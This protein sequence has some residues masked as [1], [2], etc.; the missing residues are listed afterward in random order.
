M[1]TARSDPMKPVMHAPRP[2]G[3]RISTI[4]MAAQ[5]LSRQSRNG[6]P[7]SDYGCG[8][9]CGCGCRAVAAAMG[10]LVDAL[11]QVLTNDGASAPQPVAGAAARLARSSYDTMASSLNGMNH[12]ADPTPE[13]PS[14]IGSITPRRT[15]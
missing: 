13:H 4:S 10:Q 15:R 14:R 12:T 5:E 3:E 9:G 2:D 11:P 8:C 6:G 1:I 7:G